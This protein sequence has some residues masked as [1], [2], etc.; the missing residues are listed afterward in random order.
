MVWWIYGTY[1]WDISYILGDISILWKEKE[2][3]NFPNLTPGHWTNNMT[4]Y[5]VMGHIFEPSSFAWLFPCGIQL[6][7]ISL[8]IN[9]NVKSL[10]G[11]LWV[12]SVQYN[13]NLIYFS[14]SL[15]CFLTLS[16]TLKYLSF[17]LHWTRH[18]IWSVLHVYNS[19]DIVSKSSNS[20]EYRA[21]KHLL[22]SKLCFSFNCITNG[23]MYFLISFKIV[24]LFLIFIWNPSFIGTR[25][26]LHHFFSHVWAT[27][28]SKLHISLLKKVHLIQLMTIGQSREW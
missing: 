15:N 10:G 8:N 24:Y 11:L 18:H 13:I 14:Q 12:H 2:N 17:S 19:T 23:E 27:Q 7:Q 4:L 1:I 22:L 28:K 9:L 21:Q 25:S 20:Q 3:L 5:M 26:V 16:H 6:A